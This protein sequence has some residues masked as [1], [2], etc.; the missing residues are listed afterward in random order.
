[1]R[2]DY[3]CERLSWQYQDTQ[4]TLH[5][6]PSVKDPM[7][8]SLNHTTIAMDSAH[9]HKPHEKG[10]R[11][12]GKSCFHGSGQLDK[13]LWNSTASGQNHMTLA[14]RKSPKLSIVW[15]NIKIPRPLHR[16]RERADR[17]WIGEAEKVQEWEVKEDQRSCFG[18]FTPCLEGRKNV[19][20]FWNS[21]W[22]STCWYF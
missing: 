7:D 5:V 10:R 1:M 22:K 9:S 21:S 16:G 4:L 8:K 3:P 13:R 14:H 12:R 11:E 18:V 19:F 2:R 20:Q 6:K 15:D 17:R